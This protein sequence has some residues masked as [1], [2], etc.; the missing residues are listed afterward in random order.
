MA[1][2]F[3]GIGNWVQKKILEPLDDLLKGEVGRM[4]EDEELAKK[5]MADEKKRAEN[6]NTEAKNGVQIAGVP[7]YVIPLIIASVFIYYV[8][9]E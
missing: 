6:K 7:K 3:K 1:L 8:L 5:R 2:N 4:K 9:K